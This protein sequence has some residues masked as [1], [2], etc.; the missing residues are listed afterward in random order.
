[1]AAIWGRSLALSRIGIDEDIFL[2]LGGD[3]LAAVQILSDVR[4][5]FGRELPLEA[6]MGT[7]TVA[8]LS[9]RERRHD[10]T[11]GIVSSD[12][13]VM[14]EVRV[15]SA[16]RAA[17]DAYRLRERFDGTI[18]CFR[19]RDM[20]APPHGDHRGL[21]AQF[22]SR[23]LVEVSVPG[24]HGEFRLDPQCAAVIAGLDSLDRQPG[25]GD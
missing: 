14:A 13:I 10:W 15:A 2:D 16:H 9:A 6:F 21:W 3:S 4:E 20:P 12:R 11:A 22:A 17:L 24:I 7:A 25:R 5:I 18:V 23:G 19:C 1:M 8:A